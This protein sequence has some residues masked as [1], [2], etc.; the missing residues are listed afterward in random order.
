MSSCPTCQVPHPFQ[1]ALW[2][3][4]RYVAYNSCRGCTRQWWTDEVTGAR[5]PVSELLELV[6][7]VHAAAA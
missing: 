5:L 1:L 3:T 6:D 7:P 4:N 2:L